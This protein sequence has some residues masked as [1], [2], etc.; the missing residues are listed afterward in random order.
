MPLRELTRRAGA[1]FILN[2]RFDLALA[3]QAD[4]V[5]LGQDLGQWSGRCRQVAPL[6]VGGGGRGG[7]GAVKRA[8]ALAGSGSGSAAEWIAAETGGT[9]W[10]SG[11]TVV[12]AGTAGGPSADAGRVWI[13]GVPGG[14][15]RPGP[16]GPVASAGL[17]DCSPYPIPSMM[18]LKVGLGRMTSVAFAASGA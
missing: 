6:G 5:H 3:A 14:V 17:A 15:Q 4:G 11:C 1:L 2:D 10:V 13:G 16:D 9:T 8:G 12:S 7:T 18:A